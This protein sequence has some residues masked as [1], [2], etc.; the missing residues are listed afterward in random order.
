[1]VFFVEEDDVLF[2]SYVFVVCVIEDVF[3][4]FIVVFYDVLDFVVC[5]V[6]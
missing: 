6:Y 2:V 3:N 4:F 5:V 1:M